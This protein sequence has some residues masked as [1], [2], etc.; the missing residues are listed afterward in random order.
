M[1]IA[2]WLP[3]ALHEPGPAFESIKP[4]DKKLRIEQC[5]GSDPA[6]GVGQCFQAVLNEVA[7]PACIV[8]AMEEFIEAKDSRG[9]CGPVGRGEI[10]GQTLV[11]LETW[12]LHVLQFV[13]ELGPALESIFARDD[14][15]RVG[16][17][18]IS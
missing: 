13:H 14:K 16:Q 10:L 5:E 15:L 3:T 2:G 8:R 4:R 1:W 7:N 17:N 6:F 18:R 9:L 12:R 11:L